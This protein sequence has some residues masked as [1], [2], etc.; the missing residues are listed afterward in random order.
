V[1]RATSQPEMP[2]R[3]RG[4]SN[5]IRRV[6]LVLL[7]LYGAYSG[8]WGYFSPR[9]WDE[10]FPGFGLTWLPRMGPFNEHFAKDVNAMYLGLVVVTF[11]VLIPWIGR[12]SLVVFMGAVW[13]TFNVLHLIYHARMLDMFEPRDRVLGIFSLCLVAFFSALLVI[14]QRRQSDRPDLEAKA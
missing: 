13:L 9:A 5:I 2:S 11:F 1:L 3:L 12:E 4:M 10:R 8:L 7:I 14:P 6:C